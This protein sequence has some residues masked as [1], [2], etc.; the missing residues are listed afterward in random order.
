LNSYHLGNDVLA[1]LLEANT[2][3]ARADVLRELV[4]AA[5]RRPLNGALEGRVFR[6]REA[7]W[8]LE[9]T[10]AQ[11]VMC[12]PL[13]LNAI[14][15]YRREP[16]IAPRLSQ[17][18]PEF[19][20]TGIALAEVQRFAQND[21][22]LPMKAAKRNDTT[23]RIPTPALMHVKDQH[24]CALLE[25]SKD[26]SEYFME[27][28]TLGV[29]RW[30]DTAA[31]DAMSSGSFL[32]A[33]N[34]LPAG[35]TALS[36]AEAQ[37][38]YGRDGAHGTINP[39]EEVGEDDPK[40]DNDPCGEGMPSWTFHPIPGA[41]RL[42]DIPLRYAPPVGPRVAFQVN[43]NDAD[44][45]APTSPP[46]WSHVGVTWSTN[47]VAWVEHVGGT[48]NS[49]S[50]LRV[51]I[52]G[53]GTQV[54]RYNTTTA[55]FGPHD[56]SF[57][58]VKRTGTYTY[59][60]ELPDGSKEVYNSPNSPTTP[61]RVFLTEIIDPQGNKLTL[62]YDSN[63]RLVSV[64]DTIGQVTTLSYTDAGN[65]YRITRVTDPFG[66]FA[67]LA[68][69]AA[70]RLT[71]ITDQI[72]LTTTFTYNA[73]SGFIAS[74]V[75]PYGTS[76]F[77]LPANSMGS[78]RIVEATDPLGGKE[79]VEYNDTGSTLV[80]SLRSPPKSVTVGGQAVSFNAEDSRLQF[81]NAWYWDK[82]QNQVAPGDYTAARN[83][84]F[85]TN[86]NWQVVP[87]IETIKEPH[88]DRVWFNY[89]GGVL[90]DGSGFPYYPGAS[91]APQK[92]L[93]MLPD[94]TPQLHQSY[95]NPLGNIIKTLDPL[96]RTTE[97]AYAANGQDITEIKQTTGGINER[98]MAFSYNA[99]HLPTTMTDADGS[100][101]TYTYNARGQVLTVTNA[102][103]QVTTFTYNASGYLTSV[104]G[105]LAGSAD[106]TTFT[107]DAVGRIRTT[108]NS[109]AYTR[110][111]SYDNF[112]RVTRIDYPDGTNEQIAY[113][114]LDRAS[115][116]DRLGRITSYTHN[117]EQQLTQVTDPLNRVVKM[118]WCR[119]GSL[120]GLTDPMGRV[121]RWQRDLQGRVSAKVYADNS[122]VAYDYDEAGRMVK[123]TDEKGQH[124]L[125]SYFVDDALRQ[126]SYPNAQVATP[127][128]SYTYDTKYPR[129]E[130]MKD[131][132]G[133]TQ[134]AY[135]SVTNSTAP[136]ASQ[137]ASVDGPFPDD[138]TTYVYDA[139][140]RATSRA[141]N[142]IASTITLDALGRTTALTDTLGTFNFGYDGPTSRVLSMTR[143]NN[144]STFYQYF[145][146]TGDR[147]LNQI[148]HQ[149]VT[150]SSVVSQFDYTYDA[151]GRIL[152]WGQ[153]EDGGSPD[154][155]NAGYDTADQLTSVNVTKS[156]SPTAS[157]A[158][159]YDL[160]GNRTQKTES[161]IVRSSSYDSLNRIVQTTS[162]E[163][164]ALYRWDA[165]NR[166]VSIQK[167]LV[168]FELA[169]NGDHKMARLREFSGKL[170]ARDETFLWCNETICE[171]RSSDGAIVQ[172]HFLSE[173][174]K[175]SQGD[176]FFLR[177]HLR[178]I[179]GLVNSGGLVTQ[180]LAFDPWGG[181]KVTPS[182]LSA[183]DLGYT[184]HFTLLNAK[185]VT[186]PRRHYD[187]SIGRWLSRDPLDE[188]DGVNLYAYVNNNPINE[189]DPTGEFGI[190]G[191]LIGGGV[192][193]GIQALKN[194]AGGC[195]VWDSSN[196]DWA[197]VG[198]SAAVGAVGPGLF[199]SVGPV[200]NSIGAISTLSKQLSKVKTA[201]RRAILEGRIR[202][203]KS[204]IL[205]IVKTQVIWQ[206]G[207]NGAKA[208]LGQKGNCKCP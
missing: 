143:P 189:V 94:G 60:R 15:E 10:A 156:G 42:G 159:V 16:F 85:Y 176:A 53:G 37:N 55:Q 39:D 112:D 111:Y 145:D 135:H 163:P 98:Q 187:P 71:S 41:I 92:V 180:R 191:A 136:G 81:R 73:S 90:F 83:Y 46:T 77:A 203:H 64:T 195:D 11:N 69:D 66:R 138:T 129:M 144:V 146:N 118:D 58:T 99:Q 56:Q 185:L 150:D 188:E 57:A 29:A 25:Q 183:P 114:K 107:Y 126:V 4:D 106:S 121:T 65:I 125:Y 27:D 31:V 79:R 100:I 101:T 17:V 108:T 151:V 158:Y 103:S 149:R 200:R 134:Y 160:S 171:Q 22:K 62:A 52:P 175:A 102:L 182:S 9:H 18:P 161:S 131:G 6:A 154:L 128:V 13:A 38:I 155:W 133:T 59:T 130:S 122:K 5:S 194:W 124:K 113:D 78:N 120:T 199:G 166:L 74:M 82:L 35:F 192:E 80:P 88:E 61:N 168:R 119:C 26:G 173:G 50:T 40:T 72:N 164:Q 54:M 198:I 142:G 206:V 36:N 184:G 105:P 8:L 63:V 178:S 70:G 202:P 196:Y 34:D 148:K 207:K 89:P 23:Q 93:R 174:I 30:V 14:K 132:I 153:S 2:G 169:Y 48:L 20:A 32:L 68:Y 21:Y 87:V 43:Y 109:D 7:V 117:A 33:S 96:G 167:G 97:F 197:D 91:A 177:D 51:R 104:N 193:L 49:S 186:A 208:L 172:K 201:S 110:T 190:A 47:W 3:F 179:R 165:E 205:S 123:R 137:V 139:L 12:G 24:Y 140:G 141:I 170:L 1:H 28:R 162:S 84:R 19:Q 181:A 115:F 157:Y 95:T 75:T 45:G 44:S 127:T 204:N 116:R 152:T 147:R 76:T 86:V 67:S